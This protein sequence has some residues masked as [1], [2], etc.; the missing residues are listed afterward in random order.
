MH[1]YWV[2]CIF[3]EYLQIKMNNILKMQCKSKF[4]KKNMHIIEYDKNSLNL[5]FEPKI[6]A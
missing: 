6:E 4:V 2:K 5:I 3:I 1:I